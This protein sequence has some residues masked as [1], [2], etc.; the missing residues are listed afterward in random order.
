MGSDK[1]VGEMCFWTQV[2]NRSGHC[3]GCSRPDAGRFVTRFSGN[4]ARRR[5]L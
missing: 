1:G 5:S 3:A 4:K 2:W